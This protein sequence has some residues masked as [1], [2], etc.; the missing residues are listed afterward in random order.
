[1]RSFGFVSLVMEMETEMVFHLLQRGEG[2]RVIRAHR[3]TAQ[4]GIAIKY[5]G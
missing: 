2:G 1:M 5:L 3:L 4:T